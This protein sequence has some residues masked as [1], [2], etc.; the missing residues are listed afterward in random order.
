MRALLILDPWLE[1]AEALGRRLIVDARPTLIVSG[2]EKIL[3]AVR[4]VNKKISTRQ[5]SV[6]SELGLRNSFAAC[7]EEFGGLAD[8]IRVVHPSAALAASEDD[9]VQFDNSVLASVEACMRVSEEKIVASFKLDQAA[10]GSA[11]DNS[12]PSDDGDDDDAQAQKSLAG[13]INFLLPLMFDP[14]RRSQKNDAILKDNIGALVR[15][16]AAQLGRHNIS[17]NVFCVD[18]VSESDLSLKAVKKRYSK[19]RPAAED[20]I[21]GIVLGFTSPEMRQITGQSLDLNGG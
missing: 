18:R 16:N 4:R 11:P 10:A 20:D 3:T 13:S 2:S 7:V 12:N 19:A 6:S 15:H 8:V 1:L 9:A 5:E 14:K 17:S 21:A